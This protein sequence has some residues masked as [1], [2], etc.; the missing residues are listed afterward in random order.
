MNPASIVQLQLEAYISRDVEK[1]ASFFSDDIVYY[2]LASNE[3]ILEGKDRLIH[4]FTDRFAKSPNLHAVVQSRITYG[5]SVIDRQVVYGYM[6]DTTSETV[7][8]YEIN[9]ELISKV[10]ILK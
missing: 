6:G 7:L 2:Q 1:F 9:N 10:W 3:K 8:L 5:N 4:R